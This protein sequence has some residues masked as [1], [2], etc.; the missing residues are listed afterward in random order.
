M[1]SPWKQISD[2]NRGV[3]T[4]SNKTNSDLKTVTDIEENLQRK[5]IARSSQ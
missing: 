3:T 2:K 1:A 4:G 5:H